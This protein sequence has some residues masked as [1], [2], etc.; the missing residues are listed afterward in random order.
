MG[1]EIDASGKLRMGTPDRLIALLTTPSPFTSR[2]LM[3]PGR[4]YPAA[5]CIGCVLKSHPRRSCERADRPTMLMVEFPMRVLIIQRMSSDA[6]N[7]NDLVIVVTSVEAAITT[8]LRTDR[9]VE[10]LVP[11]LADVYDWRRRY[12]RRCRRS[13]IEEQVVRRAAVHIQYTLSSPL[14]SVMSVPTLVDL[15]DSHFRFG[16][17]SEAC[18]NPG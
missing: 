17:P 16:L 8:S 4:L 10:A 11:H 13:R 15:F 9:E 5:R 18:R 7:R 6:V 3:R 14:K 12:A 1:S 2:N